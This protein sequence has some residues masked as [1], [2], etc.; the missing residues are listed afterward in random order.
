MPQPTTTLPTPGT[1]SSGQQVT[2][3][4]VAPDDSVSVVS[5]RTSR[6]TRASKK[7]RMTEPERTAFHESMLSYDE[8]RLSLMAADFEDR[9]KYREAKL[10]LMREELEWKKTYQT[11]KIEILKARISFDDALELAS[12]M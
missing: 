7:R 8:K 4:D 10:S 12:S 2:S 5:S 1:S 6:A 9:K 3:V 11:K